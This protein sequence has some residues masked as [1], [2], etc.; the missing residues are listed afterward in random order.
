M[1]TALEDIN[2]LLSQA[3]ILPHFNDGQADGLTIA[4]IKAGSIFLKMGLRNGDIIH[5]INDTS[6]TSP[7]DMFSLYNDLKSGSNIALK[8]KRSGVERIINYRF[9]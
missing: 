3:R 5:G 9:R 2:N 4:G 1:E 7:D 8:I 6:I